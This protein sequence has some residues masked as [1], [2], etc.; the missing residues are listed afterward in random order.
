MT[1]F[2]PKPRYYRHWL[3]RVKKEKF[4]NEFDLQLNALLGAAVSATAQPELAML[5]ISDLDSQR[6]AAT[7]THLTNNAILGL[8]F[9][10]TLHAAWSVASGWKTANAKIVGDADMQSVFML[11]DDM[12]GPPKN[13]K[14]AQGSKQ[15]DR[16]QGLSSKQ[17]QKQQPPASKPAAKPSQS[18]TAAA[19]TRTC[20]GCFVKGHLYRSTAIRHQGH[21]RFSQI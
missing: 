11:A 4:K 20:S 8:A 15:A 14:S 13:P 18:S 3:R 10:L 12:A 17:E 2:L 21:D 9:P 19:E 5:F 7:L 6:Y 1:A 16:G